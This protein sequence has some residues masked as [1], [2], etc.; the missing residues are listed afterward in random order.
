MLQA[1]LALSTSNNN[2]STC[3]SFGARLLLLL[4]L[5]HVRTS[6][7]LLW[8]EQ[9]KSPCKN[10]TMTLFLFSRRCSSGAVRAADFAPSV[11]NQNV[12]SPRLTQ[13]RN[14]NKKKLCGGRG[15]ISPRP[16]TQSGGRG[17]LVRWR[18]ADLKI[19]SRKFLWENRVHVSK[20]VFQ[21][22]E[23]IGSPPFRS[24]SSLAHNGRQLSTQLL[25]QQ[26]L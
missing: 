22:C 14:R 4:L 2:N 8:I 1:R 9:H 26:Q 19:R 24:N 25:Q 6:C 3:H 20:I 18:K 10:R 15:T 11:K 7:L 12:S 5:L 17:Y 13:H 16:A 21:M 23:A